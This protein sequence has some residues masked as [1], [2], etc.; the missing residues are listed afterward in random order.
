MD[1]VDDSNQRIVNIVYM[2]ISFINFAI[3]ALSYRKE[4]GLKFSY[5]AIII[6]LIRIPLPVFDFEK[7]D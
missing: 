6:T 7:L 3:I 1:P 2:I 4:Y 5:Y